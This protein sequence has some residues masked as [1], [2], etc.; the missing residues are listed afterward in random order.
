MPKPKADNGQIV[1][2]T[3]LMIY[4]HNEYNILLKWAHIDK[5]LSYIDFKKNTI[6]YLALKS[7]LAVTFGQELSNTEIGIIWEKIKE[8]YEQADY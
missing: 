1:F 2:E 6:D 4:L 8:F 7:Y 5:I 3:S